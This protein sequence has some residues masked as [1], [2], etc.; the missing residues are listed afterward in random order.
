MAD[1][2]RRNARIY[3]THYKIV[4]DGGSH[5]PGNREV[6]SYP[7]WPGYEHCHGTQLM[8]WMDISIEGM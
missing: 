3:D 2:L 6:H 7:G 4:I 1:Q 5:D 8:T